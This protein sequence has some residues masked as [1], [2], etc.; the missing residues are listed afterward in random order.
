MSFFLLR[1]TI[2]IET[3]RVCF[4]A[5]EEA[6]KKDKPLKRITSLDINE[7]D[8]YVEFEDNDSMYLSFSKVDKLIKSEHVVDKVRV[9]CADYERSVTFLNKIAYPK[10][11]I[12][13]DGC[14]VRL[15][16]LKKQE[17]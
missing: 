13:R 12:K 1:D 15:A 5:I 17:E 2:L 3:K 4:L 9:A 10:K 11:Y 7:K 14:L 8:V 6:M 16:N